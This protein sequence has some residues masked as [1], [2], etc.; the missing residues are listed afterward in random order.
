M[1][2]PSETKLAQM[3]K[4]LEKVDGFLMLDPNADEL[5]KFR[6]YL[7]QRLL[8]YA[9]KNGLSTTEMAHFL[10]IPKADMSRIFNHRIERFSTDKLVNLYAEIKPNYKLKVS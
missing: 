4:K 8:K 10:G 3:R 2:F 9:Q 1:S 7:C 6:F 5:T